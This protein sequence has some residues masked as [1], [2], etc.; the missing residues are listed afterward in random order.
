MA[1]DITLSL[2]KIADVL[3]MPLQYD[4]KK[5]LGERV[6]ELLTTAGFKIPL[7]LTAL[8]IFCSEQVGVL[9]QVVG[10]LNIMVVTNP[11]KQGLSAYMLDSS[12][13]PEPSLGIDKH[14]NLREVVEY[15]GDSVVK[16]FH[17]S[18]SGWKELKLPR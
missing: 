9:V 3:Q 12:K 10:N 8:T 11:A 5:V 15:L 16:A 2:Y 1:T 6:G 13:F 14:M 7:Q 18:S 17:Y 4:G